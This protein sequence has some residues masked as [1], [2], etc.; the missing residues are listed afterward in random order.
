MERTAGRSSSHLTNSKT[1]G[2]DKREG[3]RSRRSVG[4]SPPER[5]CPSR[6]SQ[7]GGECSRS[8]EHI[9]RRS[10]ECAR[11]IRQRSPPARSRAATAAKA[12][13][14]GFVCGHAGTGP[15]RGPPDLRAV[16]RK[17]GFKG[18]QLAARETLAEAD[19][20][21]AGSTAGNSPAR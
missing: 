1:G 18:S 2:P 5:N 3:P 11:S 15:H 12:D 20:G 6:S 16:L 4:A 9:A 7:A 17:V 19:L 13:K 8:L 10:A 14:R 21:G